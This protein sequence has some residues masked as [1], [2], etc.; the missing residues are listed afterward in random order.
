MKHCVS[1]GIIPQSYWLL[2]TSHLD[3]IWQ[4]VH[5]F[6]AVFC[7][8]YCIFYFLVLISVGFYVYVCVLMGLALSEE[9]LSLCR[10]FQSGIKQQSLLHRTLTTVCYKWSLLWCNFNWINYVGRTVTCFLQK[11]KQKWARAHFKHF[12]LCV[13]LTPNSIKSDVCSD[14]PVSTAKKNRLSSWFKKQNKKNVMLDC[15]CVQGGIKNIHGKW[16]WCVGKTG[17]CESEVL[18]EPSPVLL[19]CFIEPVWMPPLNH[20]G[21]PCVSAEGVIKI[22]TSALLAKMVSKRRLICYEDNSQKLIS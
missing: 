15:Q 9:I 6:V 5:C 11:S 19:A 8:G 2:G 3:Y 18:S 4:W 22:S 14:C 16:M 17:S 1:S 10:F 7:W 13:Q 12:I 20:Q 21:C